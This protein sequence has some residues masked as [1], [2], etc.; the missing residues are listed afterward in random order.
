MKRSQERY[1]CLY[2]TDSQTVKI[3]LRYYSMLMTVFRMKAEY[4]AGIEIDYMDRI[5]ALRT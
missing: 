3:Q 5:A 4:F 2:H 1:F